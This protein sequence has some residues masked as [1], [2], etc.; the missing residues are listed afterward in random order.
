[1]ATILKSNKYVY[2]KLLAIN[3]YYSLIPVALKLTSRF[4]V[5]TKEFVAGYAAI[6]AMLFVYALFW[7]QILKMV[8]L[9]TAFMFKGTSVFFV[10]LI[11]VVIFN[12]TITMFNIVGSVIIAVGIA[13]ACE[14]A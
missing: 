13:L 10:L 7:Q 2:I 5:G 3:L 12:E 4:E 1:M 9:S 14:G 11:S 6:I 8:P